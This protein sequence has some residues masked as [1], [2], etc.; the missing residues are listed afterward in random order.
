MMKSALSHYMRSWRH[1]G[2]TQL[3]TM[4]S[5]TMAFSFFLLAS[6]VSSNL[7]RIVSLWGDKPELTV[8]LKESLKPSQ[9]ESFKETL[10]KSVEDVKEVKFV[11]SADALKQF[12]EEFSEIAPELFA[13]AMTES[14]FPDS[15]IVSLKTQIHNAKDY[16]LLASRA[17]VIQGLPGVSEVSFGKNWVE[18]Y[19]SFIGALKVFSWLLLAL[20]VIACQFMI[21]NTIRASVA[22]RRQEIEIKELLGADALDVR[23]PFLFEGW[24][25]S[26]VAG[27]FSLA[28]MGGLFAGSKWL[29]QTQF[30]VLRVAERLEFFSMGQMASYFC[31]FSAVGLA[32]SFFVV[33][34]L[35]SGERDDA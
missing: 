13:E 25:S 17:E 8:F 3:A 11:S 12:Q 29:L 9:V 24:L 30:P 18:N 4:T 16:D 27:V 2:V 19:S 15:F 23:G 35:S 5:L 1:H 7:N 21:A 26:A 34:G 33:R 32:G 10:V 28:A 14:P 20:L 31:L 22:Q 6:L